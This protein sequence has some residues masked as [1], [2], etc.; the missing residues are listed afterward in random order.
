MP[1]RFRYAAVAQPCALR[2]GSAPVATH[3]GGASGRAVRPAAASPRRPPGRPRS[4]AA[5]CRPRPRRPGATR[6]SRASSLV[7]PMLRAKRMT[8]PTWPARI[9]ASSAR[10]GARPSMPGHDRLADELRGRRARSAEPETGP[11][12][13]GGGDACGED[14][15]RQPHARRRRRAPGRSRRCRRG[16]RCRPAGR[17]RAARPPAGP[18]IRAGTAVAAPTA[19]ASGTPSACR[20]WTAS[21]IVSTLPASTPSGPRTAPLVHLHVE[22]AEA[23]TGPSLA[24]AAAIE[25]VTSATRPGAARQVDGRRLGGEVHAVDDQLDDHVVAGERRADDARIAVHERAHRVEEVGDGAH[26]EVERRR[27]PARRWRRCGRATR[28]RRARAAARSA[29]RRREARARASS[30]GPAR[31]RA[32]GRAARRSGSRRAAADVRSEPP[33]REERPLEVHAED[34]RV[35]ARRSAPRRARR[36]AA[37]RAR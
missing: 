2:L 18:R 23:S 9:R 10:L 7:V 14:R 3:R 19:S 21:I 12:S 35:V 17:R 13:D 6:S 24:P 31:R 4:A 16:S 28:S 25:S 36:A 20:F 33:R 32:A 27:W 8:P 29:R 11:A 22:A 1:S 5:G 37:P 15:S 34:A 30:A 26:A